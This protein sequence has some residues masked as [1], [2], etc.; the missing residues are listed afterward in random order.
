MSFHMIIVII[1]TTKGLI[2]TPKIPFTIRNFTPEFNCSLP[3]FR[4]LMSVYII[5]SCETMPRLTPRTI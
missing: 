1:L 4:P 5:L 2:P 3:M